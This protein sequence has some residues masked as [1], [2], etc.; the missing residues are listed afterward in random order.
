[1]CVL[2]LQAFELVSR[3][4]DKDAGV[5]Y[6]VAVGVANFRISVVCEYVHVCITV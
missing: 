4:M 3:I 5:G 2:S 1:M 6:A